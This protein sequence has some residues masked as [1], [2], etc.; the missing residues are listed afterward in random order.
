MKKIIYLTIAFILCFGLYTNIYA[1]ETTGDETTPE[2]ISEGE[3]PTSEEPTTN[4]NNEETNQYTDSEDDEDNESN[5]PNTGLNDYVMYLVPIL[6]VGGT[7][8]IL[9][10]NCFN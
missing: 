6:I 10:R 9:K 7:A 8:V 4:E 3:Q 5:N 2:I 1:E